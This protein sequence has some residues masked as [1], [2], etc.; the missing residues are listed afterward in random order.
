[1]TNISGGGCCISSTLPI[2]AGQLVSIDLPFADTNNNCIGKII[3]TR[4]SKSPGIY[5][6]HIQF[7]DLPVEV[8]N[9]ILVRVNNLNNFN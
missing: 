4:K 2:K 1:M 8:Q 5:N 6:L 9:T 3:N 7:I